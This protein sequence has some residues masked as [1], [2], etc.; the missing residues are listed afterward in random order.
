M[1]IKCLR[2]TPRCHSGNYSLCPILHTAYLM[3][4]RQYLKPSVFID[5][6]PLRCPLQYA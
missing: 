5:L 2:L 3:L 4:H 6:S 1:C